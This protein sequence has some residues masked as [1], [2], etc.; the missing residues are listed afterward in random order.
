MFIFMESTVLVESRTIVLESVTLV[1]SDVVVVD[2]L[3]LPHANKTMARVE[4]RKNFFILIVF[5]EHLF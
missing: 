2:V 3:L 4:K 1:E 5:S